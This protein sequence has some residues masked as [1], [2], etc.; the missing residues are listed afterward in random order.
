MRKILLTL[1]AILCAGFV[2]AQNVQVSGTVTS[3]D[4]G[5]PMFSVAVAVMGST[6]GTTTDDNGKYSLSVPS[7]SSLSFSFLGYETQTINVAGKTTINVSMISDSKLVDE[8]L[9]VAYGTA[10]RAQFVGSAATVDNEVLTMRSVSD[11]TNALQGASAGIQVVNGSGQPGTGATIRIRGVGSINGGTDPLY[12]VDGSPVDMSNI[13]LI[14]SHDI[15]S[16]TILK[17][18]ASTAIYGARGANGVILITTK[19]GVLT[20]SSEK[21][22][23][24]VNFEAKFGVNSRGISNYD[25]MT[26]PAMYYETAY[27]ALYN[28]QIYVGKSSVDAYTYADNNFLTQTGVGYQIYNVP[29]GELL[30]GRNFKLNPHAKL[31]YSDGTYYYTPDNWEDETLKNSSRQE[32]NLSVLGGDETTQYYISGG[33]LNDPGLIDGS[34]F[35][36]YTMRGKVDSQVKSWMKAGISM[37]YSYSNT[38]NPGYQDEWGSTGNVFANANLMAPIYP[39]YVRN[40]DGTRA[41]DGNG[42]QIYDAGTSTNFVRPGSAP[43]G[44]QAI[45]LLL[46]DNNNKADNISVNA[47]VNINPIKGLTFTARIAPE[48]YNSRENSLSNPFY[49]SVSNEGSVSLTHNRLFTLNQQYLANYKRTIGLHSIE[50]LAGYETYSLTEQE[51]SAKND[52]LF[53]PYVGELNNAYGSQ[54][55]SGNTGSYTDK[56]ATSGFL[57]RLQYD[58]N[59]KYFFNAT[60]RHEASSRFSEDNRWGTFG[61]VGAAWLIG[62]ESFLSDVSW[63]SDLK[64]KASYGTQGNDQIGTYH[65]YLD[66]YSITYN[67]DTKE[68]SKV[69]ATKG[70][71]DL[72]WESQKL[73][74]VGAEFGL[75]NNKLNGSFEF[76]S[77]KNSDML[78]NVPQPPTAGYASQR[79]NVGSVVNNGFELE[80]SYNIIGTKELNWDV[81]ANITHVKSEIKELP[82]YTKATGGI[83]QLSFIYKE[84]GSLNQAYMVQ[85]AGV[86]K[87]TGLSL[88]YVDPDNGDYSTTS[89]FTAAKQTDL[90][91]V[92]VKFYGGFGTSVSYYGFDFTAQFAYQLGGKSYDGTYQELMHA[93]K[94]L[95][96]NWHKDILNAWTPENTDTDIPRIS[97]ADDFDQDITDRWLVSSNYLSLNNVTLGYTLPATLTRKAQINKLR[98]YVS[99][100]NLALWTARKGYDP[101]QTQNSQASG[102]GISTDSGNYV[103]SLLKVV[104]AG[105]SITF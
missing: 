81:N 87:S 84:G 28:S 48:V 43:R 24:N 11:V 54:P 14:N 26:D 65:A 7:S 30:I 68:Y 82:D 62:Q 64:L 21:S 79:Q 76:F 88:Y 92:S 95:G 71:P 59:E 16:M 75:F 37:A 58:Y 34:G 91:D 100:D 63:L 102:L 27:K 96:R 97:S 12:V 61:S 8:V 70:N 41:I 69:L 78:F 77:R 33:Y 56:Y 104:S 39:F 13:N 1:I 5:E 38:Q 85:Y 83:K 73:F 6:V 72:T 53:N 99:G 10:T 80:M 74:N 35:E 57:G 49:G 67:S 51:I 23:N 94:Q 89:D 36:R 31:G 9:V 47:Y 52:H 3:A 101:R 50:G 93:G 15:E 98:V 19:S 66:R 4:D 103:Y 29:A 40:A 42:Y 55:T 45:N 20:K 32:Y 22:K 105:V 18:A 25:V 2:S 60:I 17:D 44:N 90:G 46:D 86:D